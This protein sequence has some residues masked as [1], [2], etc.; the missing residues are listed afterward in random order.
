MGAAWDRLSPRQK[1]WTMAG[2]IALISL[3]AG[4]GLSQLGEGQGGAG[5]AGGG[6]T[7]CEDVLYWYDPMVPGQHFDEPGKSPFMDMQL[8]PKC[9]GEEATAGVRIDPGLVQNFGI[10]TA[11]AEYGILEPEVTVTGVLAYNERDVAIVQPRTGGHVQKTYGRA[12]DDVVGRGAPL[13]DILV[14]EWG[15]AQ[16]EYLAVLSSGDQELADAMRERMRLLGMSP[17]LITAVGR[18]G[19][20]HSTITITAPIGGAITALGVRPGMT[21]MAG[22]TLAEITGF[23][24]IWL[25]AAVPETQAANVRV[26]QPVSAEL[27]AF[28]EERFAGRIIAILPSA[29]DA[30][31]TI[32][33]RAQ[34]PNPSGRLKP[35]MF[36][37]VSLTPDTRRALLVPS[38]AIIRTGRRTIVMIRQGEGGF[39]PAEVRIGREA[40]GRTEV[41]AGLLPGEQVVT[42]GQFLLDSEASLTGLDV[43]PIDQADDASTGGEDAPATFGATGTIQSIANGSVTLRHGPVPRLDW[44]AMTMTFRTKSAAQMRGLETGDRV[45]FTFTQQDAG[46]RIESITRAGQ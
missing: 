29:Q 24:P 20:P 19:R 25:E 26:G 1:S 9:A 37:R 34:L 46:P 32:T 3:A 22:Q 4:Y 43:R 8:V 44:P 42:S 33:V 35:G 5:D 17:S 38:E 12:P 21:V 18:S 27:T 15:G 2:T 6:A 41:L 23:S 10:R 39:M 16:Q 31:R 30:S 45:R 36:A 28:P 13:A 14:P 40:G 11:E 7:E